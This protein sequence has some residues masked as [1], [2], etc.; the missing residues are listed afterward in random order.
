M[1]KIIVAAA[2]A[3]ILSLNAT[4]RV[5]AAE[6]FSG[7]KTLSPIAAKSGDHKGGQFL[8]NAE[9]G[10]KQFVSYYLNDDNRCQLTLMVAEPFNGVDAPDAATVRFEAVVEPNNSA[11]FATADGQSLEFSCHTEARTMSI[12]TVKILASAQ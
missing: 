6:A 8:L 4:V 9:I 7:T 10:G 1:N 12:S 11:Q 3:G 5:E 2:L